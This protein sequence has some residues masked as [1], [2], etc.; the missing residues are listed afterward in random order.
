MRRD[1][2]AAASRPTTIPAVVPP[3]RSER[4]QVTR[5]GTISKRVVSGGIGTET[6]TSGD[7]DI[8]LLEQLWASHIVQEFGSCM[9]LGLHWH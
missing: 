2:S 9:Y 1:G 3:I 6:L 8:V 5:D 7:D 4:I